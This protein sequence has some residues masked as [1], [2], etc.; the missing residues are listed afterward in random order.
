MLLLLSGCLVVLRMMM[1]HQ[2]EMNSR[3]VIKGETFRG[4]NTSHQNFEMV[5]LC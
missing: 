5:Y 3:M 4:K 1:A 2:L